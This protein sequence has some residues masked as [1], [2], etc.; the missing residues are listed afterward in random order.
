MPAGPG[1]FSRIRRLG[2]GFWGMLGFLEWFD[3][4]VRNYS[5]IIISI[6][7]RI[8]IRI[9]ERMIDLGIENRDKYIQIYP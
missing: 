6:I 1:V 4:Y 7:I 2:V 8:I 5:R 3:H 9:I